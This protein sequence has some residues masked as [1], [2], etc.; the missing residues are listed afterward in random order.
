M[1]LN[2]KNDL[3]KEMLTFLFYLSTEKL[4]LNPL[5]NSKKVD[6]KC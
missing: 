2:Y 1:T 5:K 4:I 3:L 6:S